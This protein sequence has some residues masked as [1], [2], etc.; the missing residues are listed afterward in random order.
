MRFSSQLFLNITACVGIQELPD[1]PQTFRFYM[2][3]P[4]NTV[5]L[6][7]SS[8]KLNMEALWYNDLVIS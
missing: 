4:M 1:A 6:Q 7:Y 5:Y 8:C 2:I 3:D